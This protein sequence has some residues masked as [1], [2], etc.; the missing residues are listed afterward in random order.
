MRPTS[1]EGRKEGRG[2]GKGRRGGKGWG[3]KGKGREGKGCGVRMTIRTASQILG[4]ATALPPSYKC[5]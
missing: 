3:E 4:Y 5:T 2:Q 1:K